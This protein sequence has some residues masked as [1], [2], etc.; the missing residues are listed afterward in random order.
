MK[1][2][3]IGLSL[4][5]EHSAVDTYWPKGNYEIIAL[6]MIWDPV[7]LELKMKWDGLNVLRLKRIDE[8]RGHY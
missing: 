6:S 8:S 4:K 2:E 1:P 3:W 7:L 5:T